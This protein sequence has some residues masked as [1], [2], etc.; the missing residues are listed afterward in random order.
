MSTPPHAVPR[1][2]SRLHKLASSLADQDPSLRLPRRLR[3]AMTVGPLAGFALILTIAWT[4]T[5]TFATVI[6]LTGLEIG[7]FVGF[8]KFVI[9]GGVVNDVI[10]S[11]FKLTRNAA[12]PGPWAI[13]ATV[14]YGD[15]ST[16]T[17]LLANM[18]VLYRMGSLGRRLAACHD[19]G[20]VVL[21]AH[22]WMRRMA[23]V[24]VAVFVAAPF[25]GTGAV[26]G[27]IIARILGISIITTLTATAAGSIV[28]CASMAILGQYARERVQTIA[29]HPI[30][31]VGVIVLSFAV[32]LLLGRWF[33]GQAPPDDAA[34]EP[35][36]QTGQPPR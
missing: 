6:W 30:V 23:W 16:A 4:V 11:I 17:I 22:P 29:A 9:F 12:M 25:Q 32:L 28:G 7:S 1:G 2:L 20:R 5:G 18:S 8:G 26:L 24:G 10:A 33:L 34:P 13:A 15:I 35:T 36:D 19:G 27:T 3:L 21:R 14:V 31:F